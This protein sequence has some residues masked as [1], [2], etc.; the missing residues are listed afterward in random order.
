MYMYM[1]VA[2]LYILSVLSFIKHTSLYHRGMGDKS[3]AFYGELSRLWS[4]LLSGT[5]VIALT[6]TSTEQTKIKITQTLQMNPVNV[7][8]K[9][10]NRPNIRYSIVKV[11]GDIHVAFK[12]LVSQLHKQRTSLDR[13]IVFCRSI[14][15]CVSL[16]K[17]FLVE[18]KEASYEPRGSPPSIENRLFAMYHARVGDDDKAVIMESMINPSGNCRVLFSTT[19]CGMG[20]DIP[21]VRTVI[22]FGPSSDIDD[23][24]QE[25]G[26]A[27]RDGADSKAVLFMYPG[28]LVGHVSKAMKKYCA[29]KECRR[30][31]L[32]SNF[33]GDIDV[34]TVNGLKHNCC[35]ICTLQCE[36]EI[37]CPLVEQ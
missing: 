33:V 12:W 4:L 27:G 25:C 9:S 19:A 14:N 30:C 23:Y 34:T 26:R 31:E 13:V 22:H 24:F 29:S 11:S 35:D 3:R 18:L 5:P 16:Y 28:C 10:P 17:M 7:I 8:C 32:L 1:H 2:D 36:C 20:V 21:N 6:A 37:P 15:R